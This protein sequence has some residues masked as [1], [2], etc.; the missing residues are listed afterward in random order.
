[1]GTWC[2]L[3]PII[4]VTVIDSK[5]SMMLAFFVFSK[6]QHAFQTDDTKHKTG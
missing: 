2:T 6:N 4:V 1:M 5:A 3:L